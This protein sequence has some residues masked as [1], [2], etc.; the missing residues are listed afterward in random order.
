MANP[1]VPKRPSSFGKGWLPTLLLLVVFAVLPLV[2]MLVMRGLPLG[3]RLLVYL[4]AM[5]AALLL[6]WLLGSLPGEWLR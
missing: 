1:G 4:L 3:L 6:L 2:A 5:V